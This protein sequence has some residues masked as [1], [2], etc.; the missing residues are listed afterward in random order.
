MFA[1]MIPIL[2]HPEFTAGFADEEAELYEAWEVGMR[3]YQKAGYYAG[4]PPAVLDENDK[5]SQV[6]LARGTD[7]A[8]FAAARYVPG[9]EERPL[10]MEEAFE[11]ILPPS[12]QAIPVTRRLEGE[13]VNERPMKGGASA[14]ALACSAFLF[15]GAR[16]DYDVTVHVAIG[17]WGERVRNAGFLFHDIPV[18]RSIYPPDGPLAPYYYK[19]PQPLSCH[20]GLVVEN[21]PRAVSCCQALGMQIEPAF[22]AG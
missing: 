4:E 15:Y 19:N 1:P 11:L 10:P 9:H 16:G 2:H 7:G 12:L 3:V 17:R 18:A 6:F 21:R 5:A 8:V 20:Y 14:L 13:L 22:A